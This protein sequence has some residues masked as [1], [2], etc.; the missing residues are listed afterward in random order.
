[1]KNFK[2]FLAGAIA[3]LI[4]MPAFAGVNV[5]MKGD[6]REHFSVFNYFPD[7]TGD[8]KKNKNDSDF[9][10]SQRVRLSWIAEDDEKKVRGT[11]G[12]EVDTNA[13]QKSGTRNGAGGNFEGDRT[14]I[15]IW[16]AY[17]DFE[18]PFDPATRAYM[19]LQDT[20]MNPLVFCDTAMG[21]RLVRSFENV[22]VSLAWFRNDGDDDYTSGG[23]GYGGP[24]KS[25]Y[26]DLYALDV[27]WN[28]VDGNKLGFFVYYMDAGQDFGESL[29][30]NDTMNPMWWGDGSTQTYWIGLS[31]AFEQGSFFGGFNAIYQGGEVKGNGTYDG[32][33]HDILAWLANLELGFKFDRGYAKLG[34]LYMSGDNG[35][36]GDINNFF[37]IDID[38]TVTG[39]VAL[40]ENLDWQ[41]A[42]YGPNI[43]R[44][45]AQH[46]YLNAGYEF[47]EKNE[48]RVGFVW[49]NADK[50]VNG[51][52]TV[53]Y[54]FNAQWDHKLTKNLTWSFAGGYM[55]AGDAWERLGSEGDGDDLWRI[56][57]RLRFKF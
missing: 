51:A 54:E 9:R 46:V 33:D 20:E 13:G 41:G 30:S 26:D 21:I 42:F 32:K 44:Y 14:N 36:G 50:K 4:A 49:F 18:L 19:G 23:H 52:Q 47:D 53:G 25:K 24:G 56:E 43:G 8:T 27:T 40:L 12:I 29:Q 16:L 31:G 1:V 57:S 28:I 7:A 11:F 22:D 37:A 35:K 38:A 39:S 45:G 5:K 15:E 17:L 48:G 55:I 3:A 2:V 6:F 10:Y 34:Y